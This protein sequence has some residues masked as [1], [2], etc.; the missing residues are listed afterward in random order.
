MS[1]QWFR[2][3][4]KDPI[5]QESPPRQQKRGGE[6]K[7]WKLEYKTQMKISGPRWHRSGRGYT[8]EDRVR[9]AF[10]A[11][12]KKELSRNPRHRWG[13]RIVNPDGNIIETFEG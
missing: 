8:T 6:K 3:K 7:P 4:G 12:C 5:E 10:N 2:D 11:H 1:K 9:Q 13:W